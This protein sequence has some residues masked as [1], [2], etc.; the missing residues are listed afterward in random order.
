MAPSSRASRTDPLSAS[1]PE[2]TTWDEILPRLR[3]AVEATSLRAVAAEVDVSPSAIHK[4]MNGTVPYDRSMRRYVAWY[5]AHGQHV[6]P[7]GPELAPRRRS[8]RA[9]TLEDVRAAVAHLQ[10]ALAEPA[11]P[12]RVLHHVEQAVRA[13]GEDPH[14]AS[15]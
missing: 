14:R 1:S 5:L 6:E 7:T 2:L 4:V 3:A 11:I 8:A 9:P 10:L 13:L 15:E 12:E